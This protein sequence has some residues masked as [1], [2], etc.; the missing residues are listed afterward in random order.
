MLKN[1]I[2]SLKGLSFMVFVY[3]MA[4][5]LAAAMLVLFT[6]YPPAHAESGKMIQRGHSVV[7]Q[8]D[9]AIGHGMGKRAADK[10]VV[11]KRQPWSAHSLWTEPNPN[12]PM[13]RILDLRVTAITYYL[14]WPDGKGVNKV[15][16]VRRQVCYDLDGQRSAL[17]TGV[18]LDVA[19][20]DDDNVVNPVD[21]HVDR[22]GNSACHGED[23]GLPIRRWLRMD[24][25]PSWIATTTSNLKILKD[26][27]THFHWRTS[28]DRY[29]TPGDDPDDGD[30]FYCSCDYP[31]Q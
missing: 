11:M 26:D 17:L 27:V 18:D 20:E 6:K 14:F 19:Y 16:P 28:T 30:W 31:G 12:G 8:V 21:I 9:S 5:L 13:A 1:R 10:H 4:C 3:I 25:A 23:I 15:A 24:Q 2:E 29:F 7:G 22:N